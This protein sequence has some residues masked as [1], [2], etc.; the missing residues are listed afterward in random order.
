MLSKEQD[1]LQ[2]VIG[3]H[4]D[5]LEKENSVVYQRKD[6][7]GEVLLILINQLQNVNGKWEVQQENKFNVVISSKSA[8]EKN[9]HLE[10]K[11]VNG[12]EIMLILK[13]QEDVTGEKLENLQEE[14]IVVNK[15]ELVE[16]AEDVQ[17]EEQNVH[18]ED[19][20]IQNN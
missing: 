6:V 20:L 1:Q 18:L 17:L 15:L 12:L 4:T 7:L 5:F 13:D 3:E 19:Q 9:V 11:D 10:E 14:D 8:K 16:M 2:N